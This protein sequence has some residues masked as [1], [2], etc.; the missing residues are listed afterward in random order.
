MRDDDGGDGDGDGDE[1]R[2]GKARR[3]RAGTAHGHDAVPL[4][5]T[6]VRRHRTLRAGGGHVGAW[7]RHGRAPHPRRAPVL[8]GHGGGLAGADNRPERRHC[9]D[10]VEAFD[11]MVELSVAGRELLAGLLDFDSWERPAAADALK[12][13]WFTDEDVKAKSLGVPSS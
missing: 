8:G 5:G 7:V 10:G 6:A 3:R 2:R 13:R 12:H 4:A 1:A 9:H 11:G